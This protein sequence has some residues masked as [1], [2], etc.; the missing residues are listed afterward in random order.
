LPEKE[1]RSKK[2]RIGDWGSGEPEIGME[3]GQWVTG[4]RQTVTKRG[5]TVSGFGGGKR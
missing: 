3:G 1:E 2:W 4:A 5:V